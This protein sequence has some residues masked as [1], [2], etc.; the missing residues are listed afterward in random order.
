M[1]ERRPALVVLSALF[2]SREHPLA[3]VFIKERMFRVARHMPLTVVSP[4]PWF[5]LQ[6]LLRRW[7]PAYRTPRPLLETIDGI[8]VHRPRFLALPAIGR[9]FDGFFMALSTLRILRG[10]ARAGRADVIDAHFAYPDGYAA[11]LLGRWL[12]LPVSITLR[13]TEARLRKQPPLRRRMSNALR[14][15]ARVYCVSASLRGIALELGADAARTLVVGN[16]VDLDNFFPEDQRLARRRL[17]IADDARVIVSVGGLVERKGFHRLI[18]CLPKLRSRWPDILLLIVGGPSP[19][20]DWSDRLRAQVTQLDLDANVRFLG[21]LPPSALR[22][23]LSAADVF[24]LATS[25]EGWA[26]VFLE[27][28]ACGLPVVTTR[29][30][31]NAEVVCRDQ[32]GVLVPFGD[33]DALCRALSSALDQPWDRVA[34]RSYAAENTWDRRIELLLGHFDSMHASSSGAPAAPRG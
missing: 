32:L 27:A 29:V 9:R 18:E 8:T 20:G 34:I 13:G 7:R 5:P 15:A 26:N 24:A 11:A 25:N 4:Q 22:A 23:P 19:E 33:R 12:Q 3:G 17:N 2:P 30:G 10:L 14:A 31:G 6:G 21:A 1:N 28:M 16:G